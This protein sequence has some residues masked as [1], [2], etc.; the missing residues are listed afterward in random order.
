MY[1][2]IDALYEDILNGDKEALEKLLNKLK[3]LVLSSI[4]KYYNKID[5]YDDLIQEGFEVIINA[6]NDFDEDKGC[7]LLGYIKLMLKYYYLDKSKYE[8]K[9]ISLN[10]VI[11]N[12]DESLELLDMIKDEKPLMEEMMIEDESRKTLWESISKLTKRQRQIIYLYYFNNKSLKDVSKE[13]SISYRTAVN[14]K[15]KALENLR[16]NIYK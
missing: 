4:N 13:L 2:E 8:K 5:K 16:K 1:S 11:S 3:P 15:G 9:T 7:Y 12:E 10:K 14:I 6:I